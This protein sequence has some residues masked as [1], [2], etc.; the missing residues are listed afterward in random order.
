MSRPIYVIPDIHGQKV[1]LDLALARIEAEAGRNA[2]TVFLGDLV[3]RGPDSRGVIQ[4]LI[5]GLESGRDWIVLCGNHDRLFHQVLSDGAG[6]LRHWIGDN[7]GGRETLTSYGIETASSGGLPEISGAVPKSHRAFLA[8][9]PFSYETEE[10]FF[11][12]AGIRPGIPL[13][14]QATEDLVWIRE[15]FLSDGRDHGKLV[16]HGHTPVNRPRHYGNRVN[17][18]GGAGWGR[19]LYTALFEGRD[20]WLLTDEGRQAL[21]PP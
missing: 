17:L 15:P 2:R 12:H 16:V 3:D 1:M 11:C 7:M 21:L 9:L 6:P 4:T 13:A 5:D 14:D 10:L 20:A 19:P 8:Q 18:D